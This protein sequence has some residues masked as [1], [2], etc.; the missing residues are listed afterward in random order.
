MSD[1]TPTINAEGSNGYSGLQAKLGRL[2]QTADALAERA[3]A[4]QARMQR[5]AD[6]AAGLGDMCTAAEVDPVHTAAIGEIATA[7]TQVAAG[8]VRLASA[9]EAMGQA[10]GHLRAQ[11]QAEYGGVQAAAAASPVRQ[12]KPG[13]YRQH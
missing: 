7:Y 13:F 8:G 2:Q 9:A 5:N 1:I 6:A 10:A 3:T 4:V 11:H 12:A